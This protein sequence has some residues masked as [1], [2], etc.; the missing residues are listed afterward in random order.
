MPSL[1]VVDDDPTIRMMFGRALASLG[2][3]DQAGGGLEA[4]RLLAVKKYD[5]VLMDLHMPGIDGFAVLQALSAKPGPNKETPVY[6]ITADTSEHA[7]A[8]ALRRAVFFLTKPVQLT[9]LTT[10][11]TA[12]LNKKAKEAKG[13]PKKP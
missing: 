1:L 7:R 8:T 10:L 9:L 5:L 12:A 3:V 2:E 6:V 13:P 4:L 11:L